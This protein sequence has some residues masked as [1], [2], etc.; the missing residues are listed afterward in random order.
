[1]RTQEEYLSTTDAAKALGITRQRVLQLIKQER[2][3]ATKFA[4]VYMVRASGLD[5]VKERPI[6]RPP[7]AKSKAL[8]KTEEEIVTRWNR[9]SGATLS[10]K[11]KGSKK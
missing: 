9:E 3:P 1:M 8:E 11:K 7:K 5:A 4:N 10:T 6:G 2:L